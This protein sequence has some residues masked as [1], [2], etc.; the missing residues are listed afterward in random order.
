MRKENAFILRGGGSYIS[1]CNFFFFFFSKADIKRLHNL[2][3]GHLNSYLLRSHS[4][5]T[6]TTVGLYKAKKARW[7]TILHRK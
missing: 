2:F 3:L 7:I 4:S 1:A 6:F 5:H